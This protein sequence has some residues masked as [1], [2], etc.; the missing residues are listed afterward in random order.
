MNNKFYIKTPIY[1]SHKL[2]HEQN[3]SVFFKMECYQPTGSFKIRGMEELCRFHFNEGKRNF[4]ASSGG[5]AGYSL[6]YVGMQ[7]E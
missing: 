4:V 7:M 2:K 6:A 1:T 5:N 3:K